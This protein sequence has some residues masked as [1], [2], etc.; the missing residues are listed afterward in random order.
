MHAKFIL[1][2]AEFDKL[3]SLVFYYTGIHLC[4][5]KRDLVYNRFA[6]RIRSLHLNSFSEYFKY[7]TEHEDIEVEHFSNAITTNLT[8]FFREKHHFQVLE[9]KVLPEL[10]SRANRKIRIWSAGCSTGEEPYSIAITLLRNFPVIKSWDIKILATDI[11]STVL[12]TAK[13]GIYSAD[14]LKNLPEQ[15]TDHWFKP[16][17]LGGEDKVEVAENVKSLITFKKLNL[18]HKWPMNGPFDVIFCRNVVIYFDKDTQASLFEKF[19]KLQYDDAYMFMG[20]SENLSKITDLYE[21][22]GLT[23]YKKIRQH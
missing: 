14:R 9:E 21:H 22:T 19:S 18:M 1:S 12:K 10:M 13:A 23:V 3:C 17:T 2:D 15:L 5:S 7:L 6:K 11:D 4:Q 16:I 20:H 8:S